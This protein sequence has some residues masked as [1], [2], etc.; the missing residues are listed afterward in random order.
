MEEKSVGHQGKTPKELRVSDSFQYALRRCRLGKGLTQEEL[1]ERTGVA[2]SFVGQM[3]TGKKCPNIN[4][5][6]RLAAAL[7][8][9]PAELIEALEEEALRSNPGLFSKRGKTR[10]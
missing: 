9:R 4:M 7:D 8:V 5:L 2:V 3:E 10:K 6:F 1:A